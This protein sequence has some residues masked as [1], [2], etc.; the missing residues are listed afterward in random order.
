MTDGTTVLRVFAVLIALRALTN[1]FKPLGA[2]S[3]LVFFGTLL[4]GPANLI[5]APLVGFYMLAYAYGIWTQ[6]RF[7]LPMG[8]AYAV[9]VTINLIMFPYPA[10][11]AGGGDAGA[12]RDVRGR[13][14]HDPGGHGLVARPPLAIP[15]NAD[16]RVVASRCR[17]ARRRRRAAPVRRAGSAGRRPAWPRGNAPAWA[18]LPRRRGW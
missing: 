16:V 17:R 7:A 4:G 9:F 14:L 13:R 11:A 1:V 10:T 12:L 8:I 6:Q 5:L 3:G 18:R 15:R 2:G